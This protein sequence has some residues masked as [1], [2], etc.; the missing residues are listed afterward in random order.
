[1]NSNRLSLRPQT[2][3][4]SKY[5]ILNHQDVV[6]DILLDQLWSIFYALELLPPNCGRTSWG[7]NFYA[8]KMDHTWSNEISLRMGASYLF[9]VK[10]TFTM[11]HSLS[12]WLEKESW[13]I[14]CLLATVDS[15]NSWKQHTWWHKCEGLSNCKNIAVMNRKWLVS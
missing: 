2:Q 4:P 3:F 5:A 14:C 12:I 15:L 9:S 7:G 8:G 13:C 6:D 1:M 10:K 11:S